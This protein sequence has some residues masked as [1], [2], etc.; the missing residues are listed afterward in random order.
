M[1]CLR[2]RVNAH[3]SEAV[4]HPVSSP[5]SQRRETSQTPVRTSPAPPICASESGSP[6]SHH[7]K[8]MVSTGPSVPISTA[9]EDPMRRI[10][11][12]CMNTGSTVENKAIAKQ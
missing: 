11:A 4:V 1:R 9:L 12:D 2:N 3:W 7:P 10:A 5:T 6:S 8:N